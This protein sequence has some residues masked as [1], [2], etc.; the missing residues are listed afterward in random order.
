MHEKTSLTKHSDKSLQNSKGSESGKTS[1]ALKFRCAFTPLRSV[2]PT[3]VLWFPQPNPGIW[4]VPPAAEDRFGEHWSRSHFFRTPYVNKI[5]YCK[6]GKKT[7][8]PTRG[9]AEQ[10]QPTL[11]YWVAARPNYDGRLKRTDLKMVT[12]EATAV[13]LFQSS[14]SQRLKLKYFRFNTTCRK[15]SKRWEEKKN[16]TWFHHH[17]SLKKEKAVC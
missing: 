7:R 2:V 3:P 14:F 12:R 5:T 13:S 10:N 1:I 6:G 8:L 4:C 9:S 16:M 15:L 11:L 17:F